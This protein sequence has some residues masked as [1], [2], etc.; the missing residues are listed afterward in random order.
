M[1]P[2]RW[3]QFSALLVLFIVVGLARSAGEPALSAPTGAPTPSAQVEVAAQQPKAV[4]APAP[5]IPYTEADLDL[6]ARLVMSEAS[7]EPFIGQIA[8]ASVTINRVLD[9]RFPDTLRGVIYQ[10]VGGSYQYEPVL[11]GRIDRPA[12]ESAR[13]AALEALWGTDPSNGALGFYN[14]DKVRQGNWVRQWPISSRI[15]DHVFF[16]F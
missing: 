5:R 9:D 2:S 16:K 13:R 12:N 8:A 4:A 11:N 3:L 6:L 15:G 7:G 10:V 14:P 1:T